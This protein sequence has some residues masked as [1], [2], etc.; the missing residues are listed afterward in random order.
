MR[1]ERRLAVSC[2]GLLAL[3]VAYGLAVRRLEPGALGSGLLIA[4]YGCLA[5]FFGAEA[6]VTLLDRSHSVGHTLGAQR[7]MRRHWKPINRFGFRDLEP[8]RERLEK[9][10]RIFVLGDSFT[11]GHGIVDPR[12]RFP[13]RLRTLLPAGHVVLNMG[14]DGADTRAEYATL[15]AFP[16][17]PHVLVLAYFGNDI[18]PAA[19]EAGMDVPGFTPYEGLGATE[20][21][22]VRRSHCLNS[23]YWAR[24]RSDLSGWWSLLD[25]AWKDPAVV[26]RHEVDLQRFVAYAHQHDV[27]LAVVVFPFLHDLDASLVYVPFV[28]N[29]FASRGAAVV[30]V[31]DLVKDAPVADRIVNNN[32]VHPSRLVHARV[33][34]ALF[35]ALT[36]AGWVAGPAP[37]G[38]A[39]GPDPPGG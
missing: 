2:I 32:D 26:K 17:K 7:W 35:G 25:R 16:S 13:D 6:S 20:E 3:T 34:D 8:D 37:P 10:R 28:E 5:F 14:I 4:G 15:V 30:D 33:A 19:K 36:R 29:F 1:L 21:L 22:L 31:V 27:G 9:S 18:V 24:P 23:L 38:P 11:A 39:P 12:D